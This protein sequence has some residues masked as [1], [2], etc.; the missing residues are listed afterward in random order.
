MKRRR[1]PLLMIAVVAL[2]A[3]GLVACGGSSNSSDSSSG[4]NTTAGNTSSGST[5]STK[6]ISGVGTV[7]VDSS[8]QAL[9]TNNRDSG[10]NIACTDECTSIWMPVMA[11]SSGS[12]TSS[13]QA[14]QSK[15][16]V[17]KTNGGSQVTFGGKPLYS[18]AQ[19][20][21][22]QV[23]GDGATDSFGG[24]SFTWTVASTGTASSAASSSGSTGSSGS[25]SSSGYGSSSG[26]SGSG[27]GYGY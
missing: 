9:Y 21:S 26:S 16:G 18:F 2:A 15:L 17:V 25:S 10:M 23:T 14:V 12:P 20:S 3:I 22:G 8:G 11:P 1:A 13:D 7:L 4:A 6:S 27:G 24:T 19:D 5:V